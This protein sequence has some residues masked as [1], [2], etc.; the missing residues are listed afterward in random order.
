M[1]RVDSIVSYQSTRAEGD[2]IVVEPLFRDAAAMDQPALD[3]LRAKALANEDL[4]AWLLAP[5]GRVTG[6]LVT[7]RNPGKS[8]DEVG[9]VVDFAH[10][11]QADFQA[12]YPGIEIR[13]SGGVMA[14]HGVT[15][16]AESAHPQR[17]RRRCRDRES[18]LAPQTPER[19]THRIENRPHVHFAAPHR[20]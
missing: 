2:E 4:T 10:Q 19:M 9:Q 1:P 11:T 3:E 15:G 18:R 14:D 5:D 12:K 6:I 16:L 7:V 20:R 8:R 13:L 17:E